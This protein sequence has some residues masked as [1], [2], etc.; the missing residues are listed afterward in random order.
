MANLR[1]WHAMVIFAIVYALLKTVSGTD[2]VRRI[3]EAIAVA[4]G[5]GKPGQ[6]PT[7]RNNPGNIRSSVAPYPVATYGSPEEGWNALYRQVTGM[8][9]GTSPYYPIDATLTEVAKTY[10]GEAAYMNWANNVARI[11]NVPLDIVFSEIT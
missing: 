3:A 11:L 9:N 1:V 10:T 5:Y 2:R 4:E 8:I 7:V 6:I